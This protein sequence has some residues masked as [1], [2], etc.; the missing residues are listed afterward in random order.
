MLISIGNLANELGVSV[1]TIRRWERLGKISLGT[2]TLGNHRRFN[3]E[4]FKS[5]EVEA[6]TVIYARL[7]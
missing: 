3:K 5:T 6:K 2:R 7:S 1:V 4:E